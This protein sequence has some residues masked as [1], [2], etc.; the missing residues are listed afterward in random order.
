[1][2]E[3]VVIVKSSPGPDWHDPMLENILL[4]ARQGSG[5]RHLHSRPGGTQINRPL[6]MKNLLP[7]IHELQE[8]VS[9]DWHRLWKGGN[10]RQKNPKSIID[11]NYIVLEA[12]DL[13]PTSL[14]VVR[15]VVKYSSEDGRYNAQQGVKY[16]IGD[17][18]YHAI[19]AL[20]EFNR[21]A[22]LLAERKTLFGSRIL[23]QVYM[24]GGDGNDLTAPHF[25]WKVEKVILELYIDTAVRH[26]SFIKLHLQKTSSQQ[27]TSPRT[28]CSNTFTKRKKNHGP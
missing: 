15:Q 22:W 9:Y 20:P 10:V 1:M 7:V 23:T 2:E 4:E 24:F 19:L 26:D 25:I 14:A 17:Y 16:D 21:L 28:R 12:V 11:L 8:V 5:M 3:G 13:S 27:T 18:Q 6:Q